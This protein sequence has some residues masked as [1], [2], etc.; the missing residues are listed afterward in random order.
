MIEDYGTAPPEYH[1][2]ALWKVMQVG[3]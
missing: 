3:L 2:R 1:R